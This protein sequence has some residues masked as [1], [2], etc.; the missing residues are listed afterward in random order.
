MHDML[1]RLSHYIFLALL[2]T[3]SALYL[4]PEA[5]VC[6]GYLVSWGNEFRFVGHQIS[7]SNGGFIGCPLVGNTASLISC[8]KDGM[9]TADVGITAD[10]DVATLR[11]AYGY[12]AHER[13]RVPLTCINTHNEK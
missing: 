7:A 5:F 4:K 1:K 13:Q 10:T 12:L 3:T 6:Q 8:F 9:H 11:S 2:E